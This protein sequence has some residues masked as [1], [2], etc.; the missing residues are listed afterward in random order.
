MKIISEGGNV[1]LNGYS[2]QKMNLT[3][4]SKTE[5]ENFKSDL[6]K[7][8]IEF[9]DAVKLRGG[10]YL[11]KNL[12]T[13][14]NGGYFSGSSEQFISHTSEEFVPYKPTMG[15]I[16]VQVNNTEKNELK[17]VLSGLEGK[18]FNGFKYVG[19]NFGSDYNNLF[20]TPSK[21]KDVS[22]CIQID[23]E[24][25]SM[26]ESGEVSTFDKFNKSS[27]YIDLKNGLKGLFKSNFVSCLFSIKYEKPGVIFQDKKDEISKAKQTGFVSQFTY[28]N[29]GLRQKYSPVTDKNGAAIEYNGKP[30]YRVIKDI[31][32][33]SSERNLDKIFDKLFDAKYDKKNAELFSSYIGLLKLV[34]KYWDKSAQKKLAEKWPTFM[35]AHKPDI[36]PDAFNKAMDAFHKEFPEY[37]EFKY[38]DVSNKNVSEK[39][40]PFTFYKYVNECKDKYNKLLKD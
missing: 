30:A 4:L 5:Y 9:N 7:L 37:E 1:K 17:K 23:F 8:L 10:F 14:K 3:K 22:N 25:I 24:F 36:N 16:D 20:L 39:K 11:F 27:M 31:T 12:N 21:Y 28:G 38:E 19:T 18:S 15:D 26:G 2:A 29:K 6:I 32:D 13:L 35:I 40:D 33:D 34:K